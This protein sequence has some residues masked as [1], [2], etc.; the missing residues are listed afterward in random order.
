MPN[1]QV[2]SIPLA[3]CFLCLDCD[4]IHNLPNVCP[5]CCSGHDSQMAVAP[6]LGLLTGSAMT[7][8][9]DIKKGGA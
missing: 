6:I 7:F 2:T 9:H 4:T 8:N 5:R 1:E 3:S